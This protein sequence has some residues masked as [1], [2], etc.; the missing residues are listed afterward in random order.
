MVRALATESLLGH[1]NIQCGRDT[2]DEETPPTWEEI[3]TALRQDDA[4][5]SSDG[6]ALLHR[7]MLE[8]CHAGE[9]VLLECL[10]KEAD[11]PLLYT[12]LAPL[13]SN[14]PPIQ[15]VTEQVARTNCAALVRVVCLKQFN[16]EM[17]TRMAAA[18]CDSLSN[19]RGGAVTLRELEKKFGTLITNDDASRRSLYDTAL[20]TNNTVALA[21]LA[22]CYFKESYGSDRM[23]ISSSVALSPGVLKGF[24]IARRV[25]SMTVRCGYVMATKAFLSSTR[26]RE[27]A[28]YYRSNTKDIL[29][30]SILGNDILNDRLRENG[31]VQFMIRAFAEH[32]RAFGEPTPKIASAVARTA[33]K[34]CTAET[35]FDTPPELRIDVWRRSALAYN[36]N[37]ANLFTDN[38]RLFEWFIDALSRRCLRTLGTIICAF[39][40][41]KHGGVLALSCRLLELAKTRDAVPELIDVLAMA[42]GDALYAAPSPEPS[43]IV[44]PS[45]EVTGDDEKARRDIMS[46]LCERGGRKSHQ[47][48]GSL[49]ASRKWQLENPRATLM[50]LLTK[51]KETQELA[52]VLL[53]A[54]VEHETKRRCYRSLKSEGNE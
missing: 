3:E 34:E 52:S 18:A 48:V 37:C 28:K 20:Y 30:E 17:I 41:A 47:L 42:L 39:D 35:I 27:I 23:Y 51:D 45:P 46:T 16:A 50:A 14:L 11:L 6:A 53:D 44:E 43:A 21:Y 1:I 40:A 24:S 5:A 29:D 32:V 10:Q 25:Y 19:P 7:F 9:H 15:S 22:S 13:A 26:F 12:L 2:D 33:S 54:T 38:E 36:L 8:N 49:V 4:L 31:C